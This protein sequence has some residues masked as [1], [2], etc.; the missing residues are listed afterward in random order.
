MKSVFEKPSQTDLQ[1]VR[2]RGFRGFPPMFHTHAELV[3]VTKGTLRVTVEGKPCTLKEGQLLA[4]FPYVPHSYEDAPETEVILL[5]FPPT[6]VVFDGTLQTKKPSCPITD[7]TALAPLLDRA[8]TWLRLG[9]RKTALS[10][11]NAVLGELLEQLPM[12]NASSHSED[13]AIRILQ[14]CSEHYAENITE[15]TVADGLYISESYVGKIFANRLHC[16]FRDYLNL[17]RVDKAKTLLTGGARVQDVMYACGFV[18][19]SSFNRVFRSLC[20]CSPTEYRAEAAVSPPGPA[21]PAEAPGQT[22]PT[23]TPPAAAAKTP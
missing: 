12:E 6:A 14:F 1:G 19:Q 9:K 4:I 17:L 8:V 2:I 21:V 15:K 22:D 16:R 7:G 23:D 10:Y 3:C 11:L 13:V 20:G 18:N 5:M